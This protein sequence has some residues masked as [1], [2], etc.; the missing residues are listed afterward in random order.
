MYSLNQCVYIK[1]SIVLQCEEIFVVKYLD[2]KQNFNF[3]IVYIYDIYMLL[4]ICTLNK[5]QERSIMSPKNIV[6]LELEIKKM[7]LG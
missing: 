5:E 7:L 1:Y 2:K 6:F 3:M 4:N